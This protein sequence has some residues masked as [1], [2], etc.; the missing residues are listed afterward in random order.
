MIRG[1]YVIILISMGLD[2]GKGRNGVF[3]NWSIFSALQ[4]NIPNDSN[5]EFWDVAQY[6]LDRLFTEKMRY[7]I[8]FEMLDIVYWEIGLEVNFRIR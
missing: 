3:T 6:G 1:I 7:F 8:Y 2:I 4:N 5:Y